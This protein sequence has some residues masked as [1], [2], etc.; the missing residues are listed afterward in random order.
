MSRV[1]SALAL[2]AAGAALVVPMPV[3]DAS[4]AL[5]N[6]MQPVADQMAKEYNCSI[7]VSLKLQNGTKV[8]VVAGESDP[9]AGVPAKVT[10]KFVWGSV[11]KT[12]TGT[13]VLQAADKGLLK[14]TDPIVPYVDPILKEMAAKDPSMNFSSMEDLF[15]PEVHNV[16]IEN[17][18]RMMSGIP[19]YDTA[20][21]DAKPPTDAFRKTCY[22]A[23]TR[24]Y[25]PQ[26]MLGVPWVHTGKLDFPPGTDQSYSSTNFVLLGLLLAQLNHS[27]WTTFDQGAVIPPAAKT[28]TVFAVKGGPSEYTN[29]HG[30]D[31]TAYN[32]NDPSAMP[33]RD[34]SDVHCVYAG[35]TASDYTA[36][37]EDAVDWCQDVYGS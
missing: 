29:M 26:D 34:I 1:L 22:A 2:G 10:D 23:K 19:D 6:V 4:T 28:D 17:C 27:T 16:T 21:P 5:L 12:V 25:A 18:A 33:G 15:G 8:S 24:D 3:A 36:S 11:T 7:A 14:I 9:V 20:T 31:R 37:V 35:W 13:N 30:F 32:G